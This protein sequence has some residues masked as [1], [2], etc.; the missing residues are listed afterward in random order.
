MR[1]SMEKGICFLVV[2]YGKTVQQSKTLASLSNFDHAINAGLTIY[3]NGP[4]LIDLDKNKLDELNNI[5]DS[6]VLINDLSNAPLSKVYNNFINNNSNF[7]YYII[8][9]DD[10]YLSSDYITAICN[11]DKYSSFDVILPGIYS[12][13]RSIKYYPKERNNII[14]ENG[15]KVDSSSILS[16]T[17]GLIINRTFIT[18]TNEIKIFD[19][20]YALYGVDTSFFKKIWAY[21]R[22]GIAI[23]IITDTSLG[24]SLSRMEGKDSQFR[25]I[26]RLYDLGISTRKYPSI[27]TTLY[28]LKNMF[29]LIFTCNKKCFFALT[30]GFFHGRHP[31]C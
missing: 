1:A 29:A 11:I 21:T 10:T 31:K 15:I 26:E 16:I 23:N 18:K 4:E 6:V 8:L 12:E 24:H 20:S 25:K 7:S 5:F 17:S 2:M 22:K 3:N 30:Y 13:D 28:F 19:E 27:K 14:H 9:D